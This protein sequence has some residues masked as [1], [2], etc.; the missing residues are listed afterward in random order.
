M[1]I[2]LISSILSFSL[3]ALADFSDFD[4]YTQNINVRGQGYYPDQLTADAVCRLN[5]LEFSAGYTQWRQA[6]DR[7]QGLRSYDG[8]P[9]FQSA[10]WGGGMALE[11]V[12]CMDGRRQPT[13]INVRGQGYYPDQLTA[14]AICLFNGYYRTAGYTQWRQAGDRIQGLRS[15][16]GRPYFQS[17]IWGGGMAL[18]VVNCQ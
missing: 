11:V 15:Y 16:D 1:K 4:R 10:T 18:D 5:G 6:G 17:A 3:G 7:I 13:S 2:F 9:Y 8:R 14:H 12:S